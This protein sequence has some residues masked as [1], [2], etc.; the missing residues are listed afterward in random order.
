MK[1]TLIVFL[2]TLFLAISSPASMIGALA[3][4]ASPDDDN[5]TITPAPDDAEALMQKLPLM[6]D[7]GPGKSIV[8]VI[9]R[10]NEIPFANFEVFLQIPSGQIL[11]QPGTMFVNQSTKSWTIVAWFPESESACIVQSGIGL[12]PAGRTSISS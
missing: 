9:M 11:R 8:E 5:S 12:D 6:I 3:Q 7:C 4:E 2:A 10:H 1:K